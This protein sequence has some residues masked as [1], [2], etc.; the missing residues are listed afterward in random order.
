MNTTE[1]YLMCIEDCA[2]WREVNFNW[3]FMADH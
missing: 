2:Q 1:K 3:K